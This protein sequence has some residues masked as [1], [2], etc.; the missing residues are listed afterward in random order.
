MADAVVQGVDDDVAARLHLLDGI[1]EVRIQFSACCG[2]VMLSPCEAKTTTGA[3][4]RVRSMGVPSGSTASAAGQLVA[5]E[6]VFDDPA[7][8]VVVHEIEAGPPFL[9]IE[10][11]VGSLSTSANTV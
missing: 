1:V 5:D 11:A 4:M 6:Q 2:G 8:L 7:D 3:W 9:E 10:E